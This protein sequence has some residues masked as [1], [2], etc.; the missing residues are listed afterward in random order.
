MLSDRL[1]TVGGTFKGLMLF[2]TCVDVEAFLAWLI[3]SNTLLIT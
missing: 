1:W 2:V 3:P